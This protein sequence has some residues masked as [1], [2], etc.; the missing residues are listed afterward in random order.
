MHWYA[1]ILKYCIYAVM[2]IRVFVFCLFCATCLF[3][4]A[5]TATIYEAAELDGKV[6]EYCGNF[7]YVQKC[8]NREIQYPVAAKEKGIEGTVAFSFILDENGQKSDFKILQDPGGGCGEIVM[9]T[10]PMLQCW[11]LFGPRRKGERV[12]ARV[13]RYLYF[14]LADTSIT[15][16]V[17]HPEMNGPFVTPA[18]WERQNKVYNTFDLCKPAGFPGGD[19]ELFNYLH[20][21]LKFRSCSKD[22]L[23][24]ESK[25]VVGFIVNKDGSIQNI[26]VLKTPHPCVVEPIMDAIARMPHWMSAEIGGCP[27][28]MYFK[29][30]IRIRLE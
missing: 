4:Q 24:G 25:A 21:E 1:R 20:N 15:Y 6:H 18:E 26:E 28:R 7:T 30:P 3:G 29:F 11:S 16:S 2:K 23:V 14:R 10:M 12:K 8:I 13:V 5:D 22:S 9:Q 19:R 17:V 27:V